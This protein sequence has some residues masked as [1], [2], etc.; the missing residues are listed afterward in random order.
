MGTNVFLKFTNRKS[1]NSL[2]QFAFENSHFS[3]ICELANFISFI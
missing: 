3:E 1:A 2:A